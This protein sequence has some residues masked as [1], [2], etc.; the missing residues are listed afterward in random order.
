MQNYVRY[1]KLKVIWSCENLAVGTFGRVFRTNN[2]NQVGTHLGMGGE[3]LIKV[4][5]RWFV[6]SFGEEYQQRRGVDHCPGAGQAKISSDER[7]TSK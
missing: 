6:H 1:L 4:P 7:Q 5:F 2:V 3:V